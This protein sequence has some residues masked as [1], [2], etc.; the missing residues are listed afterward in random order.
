[1]LMSGQ[2]NVL[3]TQ[4]SLDSMSAQINVQ[5]T[6]GSISCQQQQNKFGATMPNNN[7]CKCIME[8]LSIYNML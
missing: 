1:M 8:F 3:T 5:A 7:N 4:G 2:I 6:Q